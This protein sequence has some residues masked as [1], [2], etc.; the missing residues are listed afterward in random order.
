L[1]REKRF[2]VA[3]HPLQQNCCVAICKFRKDQKQIESN[4]G[5]LLGVTNLSNELLSTGMSRALSEGRFARE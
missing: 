2:T 4:L 5:S 3:R 1:D